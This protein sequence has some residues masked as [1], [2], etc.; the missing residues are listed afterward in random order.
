MVNKK[1]A[2]K[3]RKSMEKEAHGAKRLLEEM[4]GSDIEYNYTREEG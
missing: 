2:K 3:A 4:R 1:A